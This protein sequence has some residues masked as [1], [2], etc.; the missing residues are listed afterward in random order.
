MTF[1]QGVELVLVGDEGL[2]LMA[3]SLLL[4]DVVYGPE[5]LLVVAA[6]GFDLGVEA[7][8]KCSNELL[9]DGG[10]GVRRRGRGCGPRSG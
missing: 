7:G 6:Q 9:G 10:R 2:V 4:G 3:L 1:R 8:L 5:G